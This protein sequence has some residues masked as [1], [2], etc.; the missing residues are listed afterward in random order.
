MLFKNFSIWRGRLP[1]WRADD[2]VYYVTFR[3]RR[4]LSPDERQTLMKLLLRPQG[5]K[6][7]LIALA[8]GPEDTE[9]LFRVRPSASGR[10]TELADIVEPA[11]RKAGKLIAAKTGERYPPFYEE[12]FDRIVRD[13]D[14]L[15]ERLENIV[16]KACDEEA[17]QDPRSCRFLWLDEASEPLK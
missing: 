7:D 2:V 8:V 3:Y 15:R 16:A 1:H 4:A 6:W 10:P 13:D 17:Q 12:S 5:C 14:E 11:K 9:I